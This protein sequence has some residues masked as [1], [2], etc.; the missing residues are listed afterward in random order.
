M[1]QRKLFNFEGEHEHLN[2]CAIWD[3]NQGLNALSVFSVPPPLPRGEQ[4]KCS[5]TPN[6][7][8]GTRRA[9]KFK[10]RRLLDLVIKLKVQY[11]IEKL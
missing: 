9:P 11:C 1:W 6:P 5:L 7:I 4:E 3:Q 10:G 2:T 8:K